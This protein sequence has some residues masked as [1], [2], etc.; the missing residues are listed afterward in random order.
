MGSNGMGGKAV[1]VMVLL[2]FALLCS[3]F[4]KCVSADRCLYAIAV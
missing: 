2:M 4:A 1:M 3:R